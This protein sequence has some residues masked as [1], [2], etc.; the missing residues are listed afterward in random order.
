[1]IPINKNPKILGVTFDPLLTFHQH[2]SNAKSKLQSRNNVL[3]ALAGSTWGKDKETLKTTFQSIGRP[4]VINYAAP[5]FTPDLSDTNWKG[6]QRAQNA[7]LRIIT[8]CHLM[9]SEDHLHQ[10]T[11]ILP[12]KPHSKMLA[13]QYANS[14][15]PTLT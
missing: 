14:R 4:S 6:L 8:G 9:A 3:K 13:S 5:I 7:S 1:M 10:E 11:Q 2:T 15:I 12:V